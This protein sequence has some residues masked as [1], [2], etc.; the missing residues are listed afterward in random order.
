[1]TLY[2]MLYGEKYKTSGGEEKTSWHKLGPV[3]RNDNGDIS[4]K[5]TMLPR[6]KDWDGSFIIKERK[7]KGA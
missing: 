2:D 4:G 7:P 6:S 5:I 3:W 1:M